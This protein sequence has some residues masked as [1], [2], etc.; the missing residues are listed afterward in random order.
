MN[1]MYKLLKLKDN[2]DWQQNLGEKMAFP[3]WI[4]QDIVTLPSNLL[5]MLVKTVFI[6]KS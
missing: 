3:K 5:L 6:S 4:R 2:R 1:T